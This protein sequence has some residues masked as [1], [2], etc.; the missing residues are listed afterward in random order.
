MTLFW[1]FFCIWRASLIAFAIVPLDSCIC[2]RNARLHFRKEKHVRSDSQSASA[3]LYSRL[4]FCGL[5]IEL[6]YGRPNGGKISFTCEFILVWPRTAM[7]KTE[8]GRVLSRSSAREWKRS[9]FQYRAVCCVKNRTV[10]KK[11]P[12]TIVT[13]CKRKK[14]LV[15]KLS[16]RWYTWLAQRK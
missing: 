4:A 9:T 7:G 13:P 3:H 6:L 14:I 2:L 8:R 16:Q 12:A 15:E 10:F 11:L 5:F 1:I